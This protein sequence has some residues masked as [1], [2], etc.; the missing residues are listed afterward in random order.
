ME[1][2]LDP[3]GPCIRVDATWNNGMATSQEELITLDEFSL[4]ALLQPLDTKDFMKYCFRQCAVHVMDQ[5]D[6]RHSNG[7]H[8]LSSISS[9]LFDLDAA[10]ILR[11]T[12]SENIF[13]WL[14][15]KHSGLIHSIEI[16]DP[17]TAWHLFEAGNATYCR[18]PPDLEQTLVRSL[19][20]DTGLGCGQYDPTGQR[21][22]TMGRGE[23]EVF[24]SSTVG[25][26][27]NWHYDFQENFTL[28]LSGVKRWTVQKGTVKHPIR[29]CTPHYNAPEAVESQMLAARLGDPDF[30][31]G[32]PAIGKNAVG[33]METVELHPG[34]VFYFPAGMWHRVEVI[35]PGVSINVSLMAANYA[36]VFCQA[37]Q[38]LL[39]QKEEWRQCVRNDAR[40]AIDDLDLLIK[41][42]PDIIRDFESNGG[43]K[44]IF[45]PAI[46]NN[47]DLTISTVPHDEDEYDNDEDEFSEDGS[48]SVV[49]AAT[50]QAP[51]REEQIRHDRD[52]SFIINPLATL[53][54]ESEEIDHYYNES[55]AK[56]KKDDGR[57]ATTGTYILNVN[58]AGNEANESVLR[59]RIAAVRSAMNEILSRLGHQKQCLDMTFL[60]SN[61][62]LID[63][64]VHYGFLLR[65]D[66]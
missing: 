33:E 41:T 46:L 40:S 35:E 2:L 11:E 51:V 27:T 61:Q 52:P 65:T 38:H 42:L 44:A 16:S 66:Q 29:G 60:R 1:D 59:V 25:H 37:L 23:V 63:C 17:E 31:F 15:K 56:A 39:L 26:V 8:R 36:N 34:D 32:E 45:P 9:A 55:K 28:Q 49:I 14:Q 22:T 64:L 19:L 7:Q 48:D 57:S 58:F 12:S 4:Q 53:L 62:E 6:A 3:D 54:D 24:Q 50:F 43:A 21:V 5:R 13:V 20:R 10:A 47:E 18:A 30:V